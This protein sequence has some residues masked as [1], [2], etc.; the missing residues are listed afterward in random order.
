MNEDVARGALKVNP[1]SERG[2]LHTFAVSLVVVLSTL[3]VIGIGL[4]IYGFLRHSKP[5]EPTTVSTAQPQGTRSFTLPDQA[6]IKTV[7]VAQDR[8]VLKL[9]TGRGQ[10][11]D[12]FD[13]R[14][15]HLVARILAPAAKP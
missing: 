13:L 11:V 9:E 3:I 2:P 15:G 7:R 12:I 5:V 8:L 14:D 1:S 6:D 10:E 4:L